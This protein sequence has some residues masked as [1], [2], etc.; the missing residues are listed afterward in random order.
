MS[1]IATG[2]KPSMSHVES[3][4]LHKCIITFKI[5]SIFSDNNL[6]LRTARIAA[7]TLK[8]TLLHN[9]SVILKFTLSLYCISRSET[10]NGS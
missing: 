1:Q 3:T 2:L 4:L 6:K 9:V 8:S 7:R 10:N 5:K